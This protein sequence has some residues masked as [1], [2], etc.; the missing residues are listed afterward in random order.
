M[1]VA[2]E[3]NGLGYLGVVKQE[4]LILNQEQLETIYSALN[5]AIQFYYDK[6]QQFGEGSE[7]PNGKVSSAFFWE[8]ERA[9]KIRE[10]IFKLRGTW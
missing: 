6:R 3:F 4:T 10:I 8:G 1:S 9:R 2:D 5:I 7:T